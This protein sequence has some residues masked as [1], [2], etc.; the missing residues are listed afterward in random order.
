MVVLTGTKGKFCSALGVNA[1]LG[2]CAI[3]IIPPKVCAMKLEKLHNSETPTQWRRSAK[4]RI[5]FHGLCPEN[6]AI[7]CVAVV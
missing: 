5:E 2:K 1:K 3:A 7:L 4:S 6:K